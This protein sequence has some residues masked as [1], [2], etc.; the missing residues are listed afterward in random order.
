MRPGF[1]RFT[2][3]LLSSAL[4]VAFLCGPAS[5]QPGTVLSYKKINGDTLASFGHLLDDHDE[6]GDAVA[7]LGDLDGPGPSVRAIAVG[8]ISDDDG[9]THRG[10]VYILFLNAAGHVMS[11]QKISS[12]QGNFTGVLE[13]DDEFG[14]SVASLGDLDGPGPSVGALAVGV[15]GDDDGG[16]NYGAVYVLFLD[17]AGSVLSHQKISSTEGNLSVTFDLDEEFG[18]AVAGI[19]DLDG[20][21]PSAGALAVGVIADDD[22]GV[23]RG[24]TYILFLNSSGSV[25]SQSKISSTEGNFTATLDNNDNFGE[26][27]AH[28]GDYDGPGPSVATL[29]VSAVDDDDGGTDR[30]AVYLLLLNSAGTVLSHYKLSNMSG[31]FT[32]LLENRDNLGTAV[33]SLGDLDGDGPSVLTLAV[34]AGSDDGAGLNRGAVYI[35]FLNG[36]GGVLSHLEISSQSGGTISSLIDDDDEFGSGLAVLGDLD[37]AGGAGQ[38]LVSGV[39][40]DDDGGLDRGAVYLLSLA[41]DAIVTPNP[42]VV[43]APPTA[44]VDEGVL[45]TIN[46]TAND[47]DGDA[48]SSFI[49][50]DMP[51]GATFTPS[52]DKTTGTLEWTPT[53]GQSG[54]FTV[55][56][57]AAN[58][59]SGSASTTITVG[60]VDRAPVVTAQ[61]T[62]SVNDGASLNFE[63]SAA[64]PDGQAI[65]SLIATDM[66]IGA[67]FT[68]GPDNTTGTF[69]WTPTLAQVGGHMVTFTAANA[70]S[71]SASTTITVS[72]VTGVEPTPGIPSRPTIAPSPMRSQSTLSFH[73][74]F[75]G[76]L[77]VSIHD[78]TGRC[79]RHV[80]SLADAP[81]GVHRL[82][83]DG[84]ADTGE[85]LKSGMYFYNIRTPRGAKTGR[86]V[87]AR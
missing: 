56:F 72:A 60:D 86:M 10:A 25:L 37:G 59:L 39:G 82:A 41:G 71:G 79:V 9:G 83:I 74:P 80:V 40:Y 28:V 48:I 26:D 62:A 49:A 85:L 20:P 55:T 29:A 32:A 31:N 14:S 21:G 22:G 64:D 67:T 8:T 78:L 73:M 76:F 53:F 84:R 6:F 68:A 50:T 47:S 7:S 44:S 61:A 3:S 13:A 16:S 27:V 34:T 12:T 77:E 65:T 11:Q 23:N 57:T 42:P 19:G 54:D 17:A 58:A 15:V 51:T 2:A 5:A 43:T 70:L 24:A 45:L 52:L 33:V 87:I 75:A 4:L 38:V 81:A 69:S 66:P 30:G 35:M 1:L 63:V 36:T 18:G 46:V